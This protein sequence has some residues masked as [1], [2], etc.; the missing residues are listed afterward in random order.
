MLGNNCSVLLEGK[1][2]DL[3]EGDSFESGVS[4]SL[5]AFPTAEI[6]VKQGKINV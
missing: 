2:L 3:Q 1:T 5:G 6:D 4:S